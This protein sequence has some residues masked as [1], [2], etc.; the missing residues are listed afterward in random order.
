VRERPNRGFGG[1]GG[2]CSAGFGGGGG[3]CSAGFGGGGGACWAV[4]SVLL[5]ILDNLA[6]SC[7]IFASKDFFDVVFDF[8][9]D[10]VFVVFFRFLV[11]KWFVYMMYGL[12]RLWSLSFVKIP[13]K[14][15]YKKGSENLAK[16]Y[17]HKMQ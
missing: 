12:F 14:S 7:A 10:F 11:A 2:A 15:R 1:G 8:V 4:P 13:F 16:F 3:A 6:S 17:M 5:E 9:F